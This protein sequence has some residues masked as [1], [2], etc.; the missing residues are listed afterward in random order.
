MSP[1]RYFW[2]FNRLADIVFGSGEA[3]PPMACL[4][5]VSVLPGNRLV[6]RTLSRLSKSLHQWHYT[7]DWL[8]FLP[9]L[10]SWASLEK[11]L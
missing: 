1:K 2:C 9:R 3:L 8:Q 11:H 6:P 4:L 5:A 7:G 10:K